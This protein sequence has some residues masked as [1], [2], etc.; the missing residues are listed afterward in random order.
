MS[1][2]ER[3][4]QMLTRRGIIFSA[5]MTIPFGALLSRL[6]V[7]QVVA[8]QEYRRLSDKNRIS[9][10][11]TFP[12]R[13]HIYDQDGKILA[14]NF[15]AFRLVIVPERAQDT[16]E[17][18]T[19]VATL[20]DLPLS[21]QESAIKKVAKLPGFT[22]VPVKD[23]LT[24]PEVAR[25]QVNLPDLPGVDVDEIQARKYP[26][27]DLAAHLLG[28]M[29]PITK[30]QL[31]KSTDPLLKQPDFRIGRKGAESFFD[32]KLRGHAG[33]DHI[34]VNA[35]GREVR[36]ISQ[37]P[38]KSG[39]DLHLSLVTS[40]Q[41]AAAEKLGSKRGAVVVMDV[42][43]GAVLALTSTPSFNP[44]DF[45]YGL[46]NA[47][48]SK[49]LDN[50]DKPLLNRCCQGLYAPGSTFK[51]LV[52]LAGLEE[53]LITPKESFDCTGKMAFGGRDFH[54]WEEDGHGDTN[55]HN[56][57]AKSCDIYFYELGLR[58]G[59]DKMKHYANLFGLG[60]KTGVFL[61][62]SKGVIPSR[63]WKRHALGKRWQKGENLITAIGQG[64]VLTTPIQLAVMS[65]R[66]ATGKKV[67]PTLTMPT[68]QP[69]FEDMPFK[70][71]NL[72]IIQ[73][74]MSAV[75]NKSYGTAYGSRLSRTEIAG[76]TGTSQ[77]VSRRHDKDT[78]LADILEQERTNAL[79]VGY[80]P[81]VKPRFAVCVMLENA[82]SGSKAAAPVGRDSL[83][84]AL[85][86]QRSKHK[87]I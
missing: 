29:G 15:K 18:L 2:F 71:G 11:L 22:A 4:Q 45:V 87:E 77:V 16:K 52:A 69:Q 7:L 72:K 44:N 27:N 50:P 21:A 63:E 34:E 73:D 59:V 38:A 25:L 30:K 84:A 66:L 81:A 80:A 85:K 36:I 76:K 60:E 3:K 56:A 82:G 12:Q 83:L 55:M 78:L 13:G 49:L 47:N 32:D 14:D 43:N 61:P 41:K 57:I 33:S 79:F 23:F 17:V 67:I 40:I 35:R 1:S 39:E 20:I 26:N 6:Y 28:Y 70:E 68:S 24:F 86:W 65:A 64:F 37:I 51:M 46:N 10:R 31:E 8:G 5:A 19:R 75:V 48:W 54:C 74:A 58:L 53:G 9:L 42:E 62:E